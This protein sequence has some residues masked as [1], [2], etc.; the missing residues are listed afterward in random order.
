MIS[1]EQLKQRF[2]VQNVPPYGE[3]VVVHG[4]EFDPDWEAMLDEEGYACIFTEIGG[5]QVTLVPTIKRHRG[6]SEKTVYEPRTE[7]PTPQPTR[8]HPSGMKGPAWSQEDEDRLVKRVTE[9]GGRVTEALTKEFPGRS[10]HALKQILLTYLS[11][12]GGHSR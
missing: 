10:Y 12:I 1:L 3:C 5:K 11:W 6:K 9:V 2:P 7:P 4:T 8:K